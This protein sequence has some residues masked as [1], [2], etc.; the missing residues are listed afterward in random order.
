MPGHIAARLKER[1][2]RDY[3]IAPDE[4]IV[5]VRFTTD[6]LAA[7]WRAVQRHRS[8]HQPPP[9]PFEIRLEVQAGCEYLERLLP[10]EPLAEE[11]L[12]KLLSR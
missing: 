5:E 8:Q 4:R 10:T 12:L 2:G 7:Q 11:P 3:P 1:M 6:E 9:W